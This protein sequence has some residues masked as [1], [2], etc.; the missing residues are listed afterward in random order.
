MECHPDYFGEQN[1]KLLKIPSCDSL[2]LIQYYKKRAQELR[3]LIIKVQQN[4]APAQ[5]LRQEK[6]QFSGRRKVFC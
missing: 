4:N 1:I 5:K 6:S 2:I 3:R